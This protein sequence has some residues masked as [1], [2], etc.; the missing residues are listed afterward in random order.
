MAVTPPCEPVD[1]TPCRLPANEWGQQERDH[2]GT[3]HHVAL[4]STSWNSIVTC[5]SDVVN[6]TCGGVIRSRHGHGSRSRRLQL[7]DDEAQ[8][9]GYVRVERRLVNGELTG[10]RHIDRRT[11]LY[12]CR[13]RHRL[14][15]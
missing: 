10:H 3:A 1:V 12:R 2:R 7:A 4:T 9:Y 14:S 11:A 6:G 13:H 8:L 5:E 15:L